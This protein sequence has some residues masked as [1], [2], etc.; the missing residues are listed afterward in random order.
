MTSDVASKWRALVSRS[1]TER[2]AFCARGVW[3]RRIDERIA[4]GG[5]D[6]GDFVCVHVDDR[7]LLERPPGV[8]RIVGDARRDLVPSEGGLCRAPAGTSWSSEPA[9]ILLRPDTWQFGGARLA[10]ARLLGD[11]TL[12]IVAGH[13]CFMATL[14]V[15]GKAP[16]QL[17]VER[18]S[19]LFSRIVTPNLRVD[20][21]G[22][23]IGS[24]EVG[25]FEKSFNLLRSVPDVECDPIT[26]LS[27]VVEALAMRVGEVV[28]SDRMSVL[29]FEPA[30]SFKMRVEG[31]QLD[32]AIL[33]RRSVGHDLPYR[34]VFIGPMHRWAAGE[35]Q[36]S[37][38]VQT[39]VDRHSLNQI[40]RALIPI[41]EGE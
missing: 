14:Q 33:D 11:P 31:G 9:A 40:A 16:F 25:E 30:G 35:W 36:L 23:V 4:G 28:G 24:F 8:L 34:R 18:S 2:P 1:M 37:L 5:V 39:P 10:E 12:D 20:I 38:D 21:N 29:S 6:E 3:S 22:L 19:A 41:L 15:D 32:G 13:E 26:D 27:P 17:W 7:W